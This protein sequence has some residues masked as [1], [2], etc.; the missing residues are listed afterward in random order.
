MKKMWN[1]KK[2][3]ELNIYAEKALQKKRSKVGHFIF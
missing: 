2:Q 1:S 3:M